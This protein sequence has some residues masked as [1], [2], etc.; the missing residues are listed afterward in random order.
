MLVR[1]QP[2]AEKI[3][4]TVTPSRRSL[5]IE[6]DCC[7]LFNLQSASISTTAPKPTICCCFWYKPS[8]NTLGGDTDDSRV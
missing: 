2:D 5:S 3:V 1:S 4:T 8:T 7:D 6:M